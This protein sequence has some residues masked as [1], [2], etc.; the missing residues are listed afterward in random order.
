VI[1]EGD[2]LLIQVLDTEVIWWSQQPL[3]RQ[4]LRKRKRGVPRPVI[5]AGVTLYLDEDQEV[6]FIT[7]TIG[8]VS[9]LD[10]I[11]LFPDLGESGESDSELPSTSNSESSFDDSGDESP[12]E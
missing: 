6:S 3:E 2:P 4:V 12:W 9:L 7:D 11:M 8:D 5:P 1:E 10:S